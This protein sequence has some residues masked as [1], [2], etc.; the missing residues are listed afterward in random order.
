[1]GSALHRKLRMARLRFSLNLLLEQ[2]GWMALA[3]GIVAV[4]AILAER[5]LGFE[6]VTPLRAYGLAGAA[7]AGGL[8]LWLLKCPSR[9]QTALLIDER[10]ALKERFSTSL[11]LAE[12]SDPFAAAARSQAHEVAGSVRIRE[13]F[14]I[15]PSRRWLYGLASWV[16]V[17][18]ALAY[19]PEMDLLGRLA[20]KRDS[21]EQR[22]QLALAEEEVKAATE[23]ISAT[24]KQLNDAGLEAELTALSEMNL[25][26]KPEEVRREAIRK[27]GDLSEKIE[28]LQ[29]D[30][31]LAMVKPLEDMLK[32]LRTTADAFDQDLFLALARGQMGEAANM[33]QQMQKKL[34]EG[35][36]SDEQR[37]ALS[38][39]LSELGR[40]L[41]ELA[42]QNAEFQKELAAAGLNKDL[43]KL[44]AEQLAE[45]LKNSGLSEEQINELLEKR[46]ACQSACA[47]CRA[48]GKG[49][50]AAGSGM[51]GTG[52]MLGGDELA[53]LAEQLSQVE[54]L[55]QE[56]AALQGTLDEIG[57][58][59]GMLGQGDCF[60]AGQGPWAEGFPHGQ[61]MGSGGP[62]IGY[63]PRDTAESGDTATEKTRTNTQQGKGPIIASWYV[64]GLQVKTEAKR[65]FAE[66]I[67]TSKDG[68]A[69]AIS[70]NE[71]P[72][73][74][75]ESIKKYFGHLEE[76]SAE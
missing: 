24:V 22:K 64:K 4:L 50:L 70:E 20:A 15:R 67:Q 40:Q 31:R 6:T 8:V 2:L 7:L 36:L 13:H 75:E 74:Y 62:G 56:L 72:R 48:L 38:K 58:C 49:M 14:R 32:Q 35:D 11:A 76:S 26:A 3:A 41:E 39:Q 5:F 34:S 45:A 52:E 30:Q 44:N 18:L 57:N 19:V 60:G 10:L 66:V 53:A 43:A 29:N 73:Q 51:S 59:M 27:L 28:K 42:K 16:A 12:S 1:M 69:E 17:I 25:G 33:V 47:A 54:G 68:A 63:G 61:G 46:A 71:I 21:L 23:R 9:M 55:S 65:D 37:E